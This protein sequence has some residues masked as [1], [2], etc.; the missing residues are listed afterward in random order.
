[1]FCGDPERLVDL[2][3]EIERR[4][5]GGWE[6]RF[7]L[8]KQVGGALSALCIFSDARPRAR[9]LRLCYGLLQVLRGNCA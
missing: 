9:G 3:S 4:L 2:I 7:D 1:M 8:E 6:R 5:S